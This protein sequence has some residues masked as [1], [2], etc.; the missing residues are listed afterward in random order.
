MDLLV[1]W[2]LIAKKAKLSMVTIKILHCT[3]KY[4]R[5]SILYVAQRFYSHSDFGVKCERDQAAISNVRWKE[6]RKE[7]K[8]DPPIFSSFTT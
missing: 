7:T 8:V 5:G 2:L 1:L 4:K 6:G 3:S